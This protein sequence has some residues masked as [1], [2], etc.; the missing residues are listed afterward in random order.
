MYPRL[1]KALWSALIA[2]AFCEY[3]KFLRAAGQIT[4]AKP[5]C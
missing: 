5:A 1:N 2:R 4:A 3:D